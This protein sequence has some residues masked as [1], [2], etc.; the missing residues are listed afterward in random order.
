MHADRLQVLHTP[1]HSYGGHKR[2]SG[3]IVTVK[4]NED[5][6]TLKAMLQTPGKQ[7]IA[8]VQTGGVFCA[9]VGDKLAAHAIE[10][11]WAGMIINGYIRDARALEQMPMAIWALGTC[12]CRS[13]RRE[14]G[15]L[16]AVL[17]F[18]GVTFETGHYLYAD[19]DGI[20]L[21][22][23]PFSDIFFSV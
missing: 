22:K 11:G 6:R 16:E 5:N 19:E 9:V 18:G 13:A 12:P 17:H 4:L 10:N 20:V 8:V 1:L 2:C 23:A 15:E 14:E 7:R 21:A 3:A